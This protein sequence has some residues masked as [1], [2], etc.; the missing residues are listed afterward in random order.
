MAPPPPVGS[1]DANAEAGP[2]ADLTPV[3]GTKATPQPALSTAAP[4]RLLIYHADLR[5]KVANVRR[6]SASLDSLVRRNG[7]YLSAATEVREEGEWR[8]AMT[9]RVVPSRFQPLLAALSG[10]G[11]VEEKKLTT[12]DVT[13]QH[14]DVAAR[15]ATKRTVEKRYVDLLARARKISEILEIEEKIGE[16][17]EE[18]ESTE[19]RLKTLNDE[20]AY[21]TVSLVCYQPI[22]QPVHDAP[23]VSFASRLVDSFYGGWTLLTGLL[24]GLVSI[25]PLLLLGAAAW[26]GV[27]RW[28][29]RMA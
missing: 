7:G 9:I 1:P 23:V 20:V 8:Q 12:D 17:R 26:V 15:L 18:I 14:A 19:S 4:A 27:R 11:T 22:A 3:A 21:S 28:R 24:I 16:V 29:R 13:A 2:T 10:L 5:L 6:A 25:W